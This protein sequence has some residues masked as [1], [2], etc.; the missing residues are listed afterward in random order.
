MLTINAKG[1]KE[2][3]GV[4]LD[5]FSR[6]QLTGRLPRTLDR[7][8]I[9]FLLLFSLTVPHSIA[10]AQISFILGVVMWGLRDVALRRLH[11]S[12]SPLDRPLLAFIL[13]TILS[14][15]FSVAPVI[16]LAKTK[17]IGLFLVFYLVASNVSRRGAMVLVG[18]LAFSGLVGVG[19]SL[20]E[21]AVGRGMTIV[22]IERGSPLAAGGLQPGDVIWMAARRRVSSLDD[23]QSVIASRR[24]GERIGIEALHAGDP[25]PVTLTVT[26]QLQ[27]R[28][29]ALGIV[30]DGP[31]RR[32]RVSGFSRQFLTYAEQMQIL[33][34]L[35]LGFLLALGRRREGWW[36][37]AAGAF[38]LL[39]VTALLLT[40]TRGVILSF[41]LA[42]V[43]VTFSVGGRKALVLGLLAAGLISSAGIYT[44]ISSRREIVARFNDDST[45]RRLGYMQAGL[46]MI[47][48]HPLLGVG[49]DS[50]KVYW[51]RWGFPG[52]YIT[53]THSTPIQ[54]AMDRG[55]PA[56][57]CYLWFLLAAWLMIRR[58]YQTAR[59]N[60]DLW[61]EAMATGAQG[62]ILGFLFSGLTN[63]N[64]GDSETLMLFLLVLGS[65]R[66]LSTY[67]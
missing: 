53:H 14:S 24:A 11:F 49:M 58:Q 26:E 54:L 1:R 4:Q 33:A 41:V 64:F 10:A 42:L 6:H 63:Y 37:V 18:C 23:L 56:L 5:S 32:F 47:P 7:A 13:L 12:R 57:A 22:S 43:M 67:E 65:A 2:I 28:P 59:E 21:K 38:F 20:M 31:S 27:A 39:F 40:A 36:S 35:M 62:A 3:L 9:F 34:L 48:R 50:H 25:I 29:E 30:V 55:L 19:F 8:L 45:S 51:R 44:V 46:K 60:D 52:D 17:A 16:S 66:A 61:G 15:V